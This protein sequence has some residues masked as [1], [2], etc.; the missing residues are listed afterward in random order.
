[1]YVTTSDCIPGYTVEQHE[2]CGLVSR[3]AVHGRFFMKGLF[4]WFRDFFGG[5]SNSF[6]RSLD[7]ATSEAVEAMKQDAAKGD[8]DAIVCARFQTQITGQQMIFVQAQGTAVK[9]RS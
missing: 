1:M 6:E 3:S 9:L 8:A 4:V 5:R 7:R 2:Y